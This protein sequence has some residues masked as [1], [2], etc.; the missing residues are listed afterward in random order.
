MKKYLPLLLVVTS[1]TVAEEVSVYGDSSASYNLT[2]T[3]KHILKTQT[4]V[5]N[6]SSKLDEINSLVNSINSRLNGLESTYEGDSARLNSK[7]NEL[8]RNG[9]SSDLGSN[10]DSTAN[11][12]DLNALK[13]ALT[14]LTALVNKINSEYV[15]STELE[16]N[17]QQ[18]VTREEF[19]A[20]KKAMGVKTSSVAPTK[21]TETKSASI[22]DSSSSTVS[23][24]EVKTAE[25]KA[26]LMSE[27]KKD[28]DA[29]AYTTAIPKYEKLIEVNYKPAE[30]NFYLGEM[31]YKRKKYD[32]AISH[33]KKSAMLNDKAAYMPTLLLHSAI[34]FEN[35]KDKENAKSFYGTLIELYPNSS[36][37]KEAK[38]KLS[39]L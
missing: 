28:Y 20:V 14:K 6:L 2:S 29:K 1:L 10:N 7:L 34:S 39:K 19:E 25:D 37:A 17:M 31:W 23:I 27:A 33:F 5:S 13:A 8:Q 22:D 30:N 24:G 11:Q 38:T 18:F 26:K 21:T 32:T 36:E 35:V 12:S 15:S 9:V 3:E 16:K 4:S